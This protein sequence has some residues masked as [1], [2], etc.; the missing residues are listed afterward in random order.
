[1][2]RRKRSQMAIIEEIKNQL[3]LQA[4]RWGRANYY[5]PAKLEEMELD[6]AKRIKGDFL[7]E[8]TNLQ[9]ELNLLESDKKEII[10]KIERLESYIKRAERV[11]GKHE[12]NIKKML[13]KTLGDLAKTKR[14]ISLIQAQPAISVLLGEN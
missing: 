14:A 4:E 9:Y 10:I 2:R 12:K 8:F 1:M 3:I 7:A 5:T 11:V 6:A 13:E